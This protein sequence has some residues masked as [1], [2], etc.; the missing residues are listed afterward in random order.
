MVCDDFTGA[1]ILVSE[2]A[3]LEGDDW[4]GVADGF[5]LGGNGL[6]DVVGSDFKGAGV[7]FIA[8]AGVL[9]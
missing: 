4:V 3:V 2:D 8:A 6:C 1:V 9:S 7:V 5:A